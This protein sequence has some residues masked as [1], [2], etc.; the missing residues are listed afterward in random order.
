MGYKIAITGGIG[1]G[2]STVCD[3][4]KEQGYK[5]FSCDEIYKDLLCDA[6]YVKQ[7][8][9]TFPN[10]VENNCINLKKLSSIVFDNAATLKKLNAIAHP[11]IMQS[12]LKQMNATD[13]KYVFAEVPLLFE[14]EYEGLFDKIIIVERNRNERISS[15]M[16]RSNLT[17]EEVLSRIQM[18]FPYETQ[19]AKNH[20]A[21]VNAI[22]IQ[23][24]GDLNRLKENVL[25]ILTLL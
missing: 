9:T 10:V 21:K 11:A 20:F 25:A 6:S 13:D 5:V 8:E 18:Q 3:I 12:L 7:I 23:N 14:G 22:I 2:K 19:A 24:V 1:S 4:I 15:V 16:E 17:R